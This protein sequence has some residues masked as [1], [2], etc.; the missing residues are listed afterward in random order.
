MFCSLGDRPHDSWMQESSIRML[1]YAGMTMDV[2][3]WTVF[4]LDDWVPYSRADAP[5]P[6]SF[7][8]VPLIQD[9]ARS[10]GAAPAVPGRLPSSTIIF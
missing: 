9:V 6:D 10:S 8:L 2:G 1:E 7:R 5:P 4:G 3:G